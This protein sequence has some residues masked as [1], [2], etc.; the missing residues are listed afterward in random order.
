MENRKS[1]VFINNGYALKRFIRTSDKRRLFEKFAFKEILSF[2]F[3]VFHQI[4]TSAKITPIALPSTVAL[5]MR[6]SELFCDRSDENHECVRRLLKIRARRQR[7]TGRFV[8]VVDIN[9]V[10]RSLRAN[11]AHPNTDNK[12]RDN[13]RRLPPPRPPTYVHKFLSR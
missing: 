7:E 2:F 13:D 10:V 11:T 3:F 12:N 6:N 8:V 1:F 9:S 5:S 4:G